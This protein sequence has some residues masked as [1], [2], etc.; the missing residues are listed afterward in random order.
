MLYWKFGWFKK[1]IQRK[2]R[3]HKII[4]LLKILLEIALFSKKILNVLLS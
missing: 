1:D 3:P 2:S 4:N